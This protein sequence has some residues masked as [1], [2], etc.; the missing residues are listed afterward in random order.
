MNSTVLTRFHNNS[1]LT[2]LRLVYKQ[3]PE[4]LKTYYETEEHNYGHLHSY[5]SSDAQIVYQDHEYHG[6]I[7]FYNA[8]L[9]NHINSIMRVHVSMNSLPFDEKS[10]IVMS[11]G[12]LTYNH[13][14][15]INHF[16]ETF[17][18]ERDNSDRLY[19]TSYLFRT[20]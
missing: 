5:F 19:I 6:F 3:I 15:N 18:M 2:D 14:P 12:T 11:S 13:S 8:L 17:I 16:A 20:I 4:V 9:N 7:N 10:V 1:N